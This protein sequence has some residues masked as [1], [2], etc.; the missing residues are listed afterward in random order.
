MLFLVAQDRT[1]FQLRYNIFLI[2]SRGL[3]LWISRLCWWTLAF[4]YIVT[5]KY[6]KAT[7]LYKHYQKHANLQPVGSLVD[8]L[9]FGTIKPW[10]FCCHTIR[11]YNTCISQITYILELDVIRLLFKILKIPLSSWKIWLQR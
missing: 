6:K 9:F 2:C 11:T 5:K 8:F 1:R 10:V 3:L 7:Q 4:F